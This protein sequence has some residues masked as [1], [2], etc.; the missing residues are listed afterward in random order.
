MSKATINFT[1][2]LQGKPALSCG[3]TPLV[4]DSKAS[5]SLELPVAYAEGGKVLEVVK[6]SSKWSESKIKTIG[7][8]HEEDKVK[9]LNE[10]I[11]ALLFTKG[12]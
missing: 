7:F 10:C 1:E 4:T 9:V 12:R 11:F 5:S 2:L 6:V 3:K 8:L